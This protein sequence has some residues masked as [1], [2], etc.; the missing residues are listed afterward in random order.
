MHSHES[1]NE[2]EGAIK[3]ISPEKERRDTKVGHR[4]DLQYPWSL[5]LEKVQRG[6]KKFRSKIHIVGWN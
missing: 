6:F 4:P 2:T 3:E 1:E 5:R